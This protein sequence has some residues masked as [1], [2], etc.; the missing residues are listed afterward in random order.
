MAQL[1]NYDATGGETIG[2]RSPLPAGEYVIALVKSDQVQAKSGNG[3]SFIACEFEVKE[4]PAGVACEGR[5]L[6]TNLNLWN[7]N[8]QA[9]EFAQRELNSIMHACGKLRISDTEELHGIPMRAMVGF[10]KGDR[11]RNAIKSYKP[12]NA[13]PGAAGGQTFGAGAQQGG[14]QSSGGTAPWQRRSA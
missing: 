6:W 11:T 1:G 8:S 9:V 14:G 5:R 3:N 10:D 2:D 7:G 4:G 12:L 13:A